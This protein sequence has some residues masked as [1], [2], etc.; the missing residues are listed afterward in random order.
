MYAE[1]N[2]GGAEHEVPLPQCLIDTIGQTDKFRIKVSLFNFTSKRL[3]L[4]VTKIVSP[5]VLPPKNRSAHVPALPLSASQDNPTSSAVDSSVVTE[6]S[7]G[8]SSYANS[9]PIYS[10]GEQK[11]A[12]RSKRNG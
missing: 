11:K 3:S 12:K 5:A 2:G 4:T 6:S 8:G 7:G 1:E 9:D 10:T